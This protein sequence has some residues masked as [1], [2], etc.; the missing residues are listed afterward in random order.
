MSSLSTS[1]AGKVRRERGLLAQLEER[2]AR[3]VLPR[4]SQQR[5]RFVHMQKGLEN[6]LKFFAGEHPDLAIIGL[7]YINAPS[8]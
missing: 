3:V 8:S 2:E 5:R 1:Q 6:Q 4:V 7:L